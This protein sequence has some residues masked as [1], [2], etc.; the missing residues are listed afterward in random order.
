MQLFRNL[1]LILPALFMA[2]CVTLPAPSGLNKDSETAAAVQ[3][4]P[5]KA[6]ATAVAPEQPERP[7]AG[8]TQYCAERGWS[9]Q[10]AGGRTGRPARAGSISRSITI[11]RWRARPGIRWS[12]SGATRIAVYA[13]DDEAAAAAADSGPKSIRITRTPI[14]C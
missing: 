12:L 13:R 4:A 1:P 5:D 14:R 6:K 3:T 8:Q 10:G 9:C 7:R 2:A 11:W